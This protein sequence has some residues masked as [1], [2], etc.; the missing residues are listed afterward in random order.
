MF[1]PYYYTVPAPEALFTAPTRMNLPETTDWASFYPTVQTPAP[2][3]P[4]SPDPPYM[5]MASR[6]RE[7]IDLETFRSINPDWK[8]N[9][10]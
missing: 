2:A 6:M 9:T 5:S 7:D 4:R 10:I 8:I 1:N 3:P